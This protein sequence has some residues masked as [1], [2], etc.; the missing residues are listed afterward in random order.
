LLLGP[1]AWAS[2]PG[3]YSYSSLAAIERCPR[4]WQLA[5]SGYGDMP[6]FPTRPHPAAVE[7]EIVH[8]LLDRLF[9]ALAVRG[10]PPVG[11][12][13]FRE[14]LADVD[15]QGGARELLAENECW[16]A[17]HPRASAF[18]LR[19]GHQQLVNRVIRL[20]RGLY[21]DAAVTHRASG[22]PAA[23]MRAPK[24]PPSGPA[25]AALLRDRGAVSELP[26]AHPKLPFGGVID[27]VWPDGGGPVI[28]DFKTG[29]AQPQHTKQVTY[30]AVL[31]W[32]SSGV[33]PARAEVRYPDRIVPVPLDEELL[34]RAENDL[35]ERIRAAVAA[36]GRVPAEALLGGHCRH[37]DVRQ[38]CEVYWSG[39]AASSPGRMRLADQDAAVD[40][41]VTVAGEPSGGGFDASAA[42][43]LTFPVVF[44][45]DVALLHGPF[46][47]GERL[48][49]LG[50]QPTE[51]GGMELRLWTEVFHRGQAVQEAPEKCDKL[52][53][54]P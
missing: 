46:A 5:H 4:Q 35:R 38:F 21:Q 52:T 2:P 50:G 53:R 49:I 19:T 34:S 3:S 20:F 26:L 23:V 14:V 18:R 37:C 17:E 7:G 39:P 25:L 36:L 13:P 9:K 12:P 41:E 6:R 31:W 10:M 43:G 30:Y 33:I 15:L 22:L 27:L 54:T 40:A 32:R 42:D 28:T 48:R 16:L 51:G 8:A 44:H 45:E 11:S 1:T 24:Q 29:Q 47:R